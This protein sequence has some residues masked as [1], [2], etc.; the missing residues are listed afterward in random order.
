MRNIGPPELL[1]FLIFIAL[2]FVGARYCG[3]KAT[4][5]NRNSLGWAIFGFISPLL[6][7]AIVS[8]I[9]SKELK[10]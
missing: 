10:N 4:K 9:G 2:K 5:L 1:L 3:R 8:S 6:A 7:M